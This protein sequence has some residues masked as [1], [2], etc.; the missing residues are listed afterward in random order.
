MAWGGVGWVAW[1][2]LGR[3]GDKAN[4]KLDITGPVISFVIST[5]SSG[6]DDVSES[7]GALMWAYSAVFWCGPDDL[8]GSRCVNDLGIHGGVSALR[9]DTHTPLVERFKLTL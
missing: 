8:T 2:G 9:M 1:G 6:T 5:L 3:P 4:S 7:L